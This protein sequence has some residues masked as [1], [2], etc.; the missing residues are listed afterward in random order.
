MKT[1]AIILLLTA[2]AGAVVYFGTKY[3]GLAKD[4]DK[5]GIPDK[6]EDTAKKVNQAAQRVKKE[7]NDAKA[8]AQGNRKRGRKPSQKPNQGGTTAPKNKNYY[9]S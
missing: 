2:V 4:E 6:L 1:I 5:D 8:Q 7:F 3:F 9:G